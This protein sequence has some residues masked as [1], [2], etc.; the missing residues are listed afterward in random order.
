MGTGYF[1]GVKRPGCG[2]DHTPPSRAEVKERVKLY[3]YSPYGTSWP[4]LGWA[5]PLPLLS[6]FLPCLSG[7]QIASFCAVVYC[8]LWPGWSYHIF[9]HYV[10]NGAENSYWNIKCVLIFSE[11]FV[12]NIFHSNDSRDLL[13]YIYT[14]L[15]VKHPLFLSE[16]K[17][18]WTFWAEFRKTLKYHISWK[19]IQCEPSCSTQTNGPTDIQGDLTKLIVA[20]CKFCE[21][22]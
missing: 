17:E 20:F 6:V 2:V 16:F 19:S 3:L 7:M 5:L 13:S 11:N 9:P 8:H 18:T 1:P 10:I 4:V 12:W 14:D 21:R 15:H 22:A